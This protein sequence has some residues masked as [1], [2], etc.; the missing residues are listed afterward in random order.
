MWR[1]VKYAVRINGYS[2]IGISALFFGGSALLA[3]TDAN[4]DGFLALV[5]YLAISSALLAPIVIASA[6]KPEEIS[7]V[8]VYN[9]VTYPFWRTVVRYAVANWLAIVLTAITVTVISLVVTGDIRYSR[10]LV[11]GTVNVVSNSLLFGSLSLLGATLGC[12]S[13]AGQLLGLCVFIVLL[14]TPLPQCVNPAIH[15]FR[16]ADAL[17]SPMLWWV[18][19]SIHAAVGVLISALSLRL[20]KDTDRLMTGRPR[21]PKQAL[22]FGRKFGVV[23]RWGGLLAPTVLP[24]PRSKFLGIVMYEAL[25]TVIDGVVPL[26]VVGAS[27]IFVC[28]LPLFDAIHLG[29]EG[30]FLSQVASSKALIY[31]LFPFLPIVLVDRVP[32]DR[33]SLLDQLLFTTISPREYLIGKGIGVGVAV[34]GSFLLGAGPAL[35]LL[36]VAAVFGLSHFLLCY[37]GV[38]ALGVLPALIYISV[39]SVLGGALARLRRSV[40]V[41][42]LMSV[43]CIVLLVVTHNSV[44]GNEFFPTGIMAIETLSI[45]LALRTS[46]IY[47][48]P[49]STWATVPTAYLFLP[50]LFGV[51]Q[52]GIGWLIVGRVFEKEVSS[53]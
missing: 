15:P 2:P 7:M 28:I 14:V 47:S 8:E 50:L 46:I 16:V 44:L 53:G 5:K 35:F 36:V 40:F 51:L 29:L 25:L 17:D 22:A 42:G 33:Q 1:M 34:L 30:L 43:A 20:A 4:A 13:R 49:S 21:Q 24:V 45:W 41:G 38:L 26:S 9:T 27:T 23:R 32:H 3:L 12:N 6:L 37:L 52:V 18:S 11:L 48:S 39:V 31:F 19:R 10:L